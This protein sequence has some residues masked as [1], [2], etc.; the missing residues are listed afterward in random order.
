MPSLTNIASW[1]D[2]NSKRTITVAKPFCSPARD[3]ITAAFAPYGVKV[4]GIK[5]HTRL[6]SLH[7]FARRMRVEL[8]THENLKYGPAAAPF[9]LPMAI[10]AEVT[11]NEKAAAWAEYL[12]LRT[13]LLYVPGK[14]VNRRN[15]EWAAKHGGAMPPAWNNGQPWIER[16]CSDGIAQWQEAK[17][18]IKKASKVPP[19]KRKGWW[20]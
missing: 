20:T 19:P 9:F 10:I 13:G 1:L 15:E 17:A 3:I 14:Y 5:E 6:L 16:S 18:V 4:H 8:R 12:L 11:V 2:G 7:D